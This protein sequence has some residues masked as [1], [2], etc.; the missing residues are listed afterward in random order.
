MANAGDVGPSFVLFIYQHFKSIAT[1]ATFPS[2]IIH[3]LIL[4]IIRTLLRAFGEGLIS[5]F[6]SAP[7]SQVQDRDR[8]R[9]Y[10][11]V[12][13]QAIIHRYINIHMYSLL[14]K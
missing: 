14:S 10:N 7:L 5:L 8:A 3:S 6:W 12:A 9:D 2:P 11:I 13:G 4:R 1:A